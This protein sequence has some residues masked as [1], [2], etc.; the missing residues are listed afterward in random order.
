MLILIVKGTRIAPSKVFFMLIWAGCSEN[1]W[2]IP[3]C[4][5]AIL[6]KIRSLSCQPHIFAVGGI[7]TGYPVLDW[8]LDRS[9]VGWTCAHLP[10]TPCYL[11][12]QFCMP[13][14]WE[15]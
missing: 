4:I 7:V 15:A 8:W 10:H 14:F 2:L 9:P 6:S 1:R 3:M 5:V 12:R 13:Y 11:E